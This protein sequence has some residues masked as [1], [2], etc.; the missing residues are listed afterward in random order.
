[1][2]RNSAN[3]ILSASPGTPSAAS[4]IKISRKTT[5]ALL[6]YGGPLE[7][8]DTPDELSRVLQRKVMDPVDTGDLGSRPFFPEGLDALPLARVP[9]RIAAGREDRERRHAQPD[10]HRGRVLLPD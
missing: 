8:A 10:V 4:R 3:A 2:P 6:S 1:M 5:M 7:G 9:L